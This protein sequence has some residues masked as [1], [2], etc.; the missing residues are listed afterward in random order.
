MKSI[1][2]FNQFSNGDTIEQVYGRLKYK[3]VKFKDSNSFA[4]T[5]PYFDW[6]GLGEIVTSGYPILKERFYLKFMLQKRLKYL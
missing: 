1:N 5:D 3:F 2:M 4:M 6:F